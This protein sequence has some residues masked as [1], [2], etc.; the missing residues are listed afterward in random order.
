MKKFSNY[1]EAE[2]YIIDNVVTSP[3]FITSFTYERLGTGFVLVNP[4]DNKN[5]RSNY[6]Y[7]DKFFE[8]LL[9]GEKELSQ[10]VLKANPWVARFVDTSGLPDNFSS[11]YGWKI[12]QQITD[13]CREIIE[14][15]ESRRGYLQILQPEDNIIRTAKTTHEYPCTIGL[16][17]FVRGGKLHLMVNMRSNNL[18]SVMPY[19]VYNL[20]CFK[21]IY[22]SC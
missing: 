6:D 18:Y 1:R 9:S 2:D 13:V 10:D 5:G 7:A 4:L 19:D 11:S 8:W 20:L 17:F 15:K 3:E 14:H 21:A 22:A 16:H 12:Q